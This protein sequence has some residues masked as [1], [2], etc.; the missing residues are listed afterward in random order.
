MPDRFKLS[1]GSVTLRR[2]RKEDAGPIYHAVRESINEVSPWM[3]WCHTGYSL[4]D[5][6]IWSASRDDAWEKGLE[7][8]FVIF[9]QDEALPSGVCG[10]NHIDYEVL[11]ANMGYWVRTG[12]T[13]RGVGTSAVLLLARFGFEELGLNRIE[14]LVATENKPSQKVAEKAGAKKEVILRKRLNVRDKVYDAVMYAL[15]PEDTGS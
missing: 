8:D 1:D 4:E 3:P 7:Y 10:L 6:K 13:N 2:Y 14:I 5:S 12:K 11:V 15:I 9:R